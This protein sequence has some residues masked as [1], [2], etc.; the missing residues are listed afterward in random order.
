[1]KTVILEH[2]VVLLV[3]PHITIVAHVAKGLSRANALSLTRMATLM[4]PAGEY[5]TPKK[6]RFNLFDPTTIIDNSNVNE[7]LS[8]VFPSR[9]VV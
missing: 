7:V 1:M 2:D 8:S 3:G 4:L 5:P 9:P 6:D